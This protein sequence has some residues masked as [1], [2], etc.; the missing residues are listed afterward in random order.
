MAPPSSS[1]SPPPSLPIVRSVGF[2][3]FD[4]RRL[5]RD[6]AVHNGLMGLGSCLN[7]L[8]TSGKRCL[9]TWALSPANPPF[10]YDGLL[11]FMH[12]SNGPA[13]QALKWSLRWRLVAAVPSTHRTWVFV[14]MFVLLSGAICPPLPPRLILFF[15][16]SGRT[17]LCAGFGVVRG[18]FS[19]FSVFSVS[20]SVS[21][22][23]FVSCQ[24]FSL[25]MQTWFWADGLLV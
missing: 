25:R 9:R 16:R 22:M 18:G 24:H 1:P 19:R 5:C 15:F 17:K 21:L 20:S 12:P 8:C 2:V 23:P 14:F 4:C 13:E 11:L 10:G 7:R 3:L 6:D